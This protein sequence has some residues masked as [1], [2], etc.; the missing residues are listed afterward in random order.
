MRTSESGQGGQKDS[1]LFKINEVRGNERENISM[2]RVVHSLYQV[3]G[4][5]MGAL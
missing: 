5:K 4:F 3:T 1:P 2:V